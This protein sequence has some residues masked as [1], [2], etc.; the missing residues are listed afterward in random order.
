MATAKT[1]KYDSFKRG[2]T[3]VFVFQF[4]EPYD[5]FNWSGITADFAMTKENAPSNNTGASVVR[6]NVSLTIDGDNNASVTVQ[7]TVNESNAL[8]PNTLYHVE[9]QL[10]GNTGT[11]VATAVTGQVLVVQDYII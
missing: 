3:P 11:N 7:S 10:K 9:V 4:T 1:I 2:D 5:G 8:T 6:T